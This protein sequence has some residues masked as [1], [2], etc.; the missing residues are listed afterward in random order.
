MSR[1]K[2]AGAKVVF[3][4]LDFVGLELELVGTLVVGVEVAKSGPGGEVN[5]RPALGG[6]GE[7]RKPDQ[8][9]S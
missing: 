8:K 3:R 9:E 2:D 4:D 1:S 7:P 5:R 6:S